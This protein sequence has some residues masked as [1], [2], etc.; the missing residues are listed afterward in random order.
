MAPPPEVEPPPAEVHV[1]GLDM[2]LRLDLDDEMV[3]RRALGRRLDPET[4]TVYHVEF[5]PPPE[6][7][8]GRE[9]VCWRDGGRTPGAFPGGA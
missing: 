3:R 4:G 6:A 9:G 7:A 2:I 8:V 5:E 1:P